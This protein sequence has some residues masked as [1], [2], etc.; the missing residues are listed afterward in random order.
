MTAVRDA[1]V[2]GQF[3]AGDA[4]RLAADVDALLRG[5]ATDAPCPKAVVAPHAGYVYSGPVAARAY[6]RIANGADRI[7][8]VILLGPSHRV[9]FAGIATSK[10]DF[11]ATPLGRIPL[12]RD[13]IDEI[14]H[15][16][17]V[18][19]LDAAHAQEHSLEVHLPFLQRCLQ[20]FTLVPLVVG[21][22]EPEAVARVIEALWGGPETLI[23]ISS[24][25]SHFLSYDQARE[26]DA[27]TSRLIE[28]RHTD[29]S[30]E[31]ACGCRPLN[32]LLQ[33]LKERDLHIRT[34]AQNN[35]GDTAGD[36]SRVVGYGAYLVEEGP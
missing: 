2:A 8:R 20:H 13:A 5:A 35:S 9:G 23:I 1:A 34:L 14:G 27:Q 32:G 18:G 33:L 6:A 11:F 12:D 16:P 26:R 28:S 19:A 7:E 10:A 25:L 15:L 24:D 21:Q 36:K 29:I 31:Q 17:G 30:G 22:A 4:T 3:Y